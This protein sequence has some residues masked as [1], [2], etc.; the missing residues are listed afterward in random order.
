MSDAIDP[1]TALRDEI[2]AAI[3]I[4][5]PKVQGLRELARVVDQG[6]LLRRIVETLDVAQERMNYLTSVITR[7]DRLEQTRAGLAHTGYPAP[8]LFVL[9]ADLYAE[10]ISDIR[11]LELG[12]SIFE[13]AGHVMLDL[14]HDVIT[15]QPMPDIPGP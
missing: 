9:P 4:L 2:N 13:Q 3:D 15:E 1:Y 11:A 6:R 7:L 12:G 10:L 8:I 5:A 14:A